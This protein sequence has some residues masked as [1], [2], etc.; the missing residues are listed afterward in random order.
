MTETPYV[1]RKCV[2]EATLACNLR[3]RH[4]GSRAGTARPNELS[5]EE[6]RTLVAD[7]AG[8]GCEKLV[9]SGGEALLRPDCMEII[10]AASGA[11]LRTALITNGLLLDRAACEEAL[12]AGLDAVGVSLDGIGPTH[13]RFRSM[14]GL[15]VRVLEAFDEARRARLPFCAITTVNRLNLGELDELRSLLREAGAYAW[16]LQPAMTMGEICVNPEMGVE[17][18]DIPG[19][20]RAVAELIEAEARGGDRMPIYT[21]DSL[22]YFGPREAVLRR[23]AGGNRFGGCRA[24]V[25][26][27]GIE[28]NGDVKGCL[29]IRPGAGP[30][31]SAWVEGNVRRGGLP[32]IWND[33]AAFAYNRRW[34]PSDLG[35]AC[36]ACPHALRCRGGCRSAM[37][38]S[39]DGTWNPMCERSVLARRSA[40]KG[41]VAGQV[42]AATVLASAL[43]LGASGCHHVSLE[44]P[45]APDSG[46]DTE[47][48][49]DSEPQTVYGMPDTDTDT[50]T[51]T[52]SGSETDVDAGGVPIYAFELPPAD[53]DA[54]PE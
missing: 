16:Q 12:A 40:K 28:S 2:L 39:G 46:T 36:A 53:G 11:G 7:L 1:P 23:Y 50:D 41:R 52:E 4:S 15:F 54:G 5:F 47:S 22:G 19:I 35:G 18:R 32:A 30:E 42:A 49:S 38:T 21:G 51:D 26:V 37:V 14:P 17:P 33:P 13:D 27:V 31:G 9:V 20:S 24:G 10:A 3:C 25:E 29:S 48:E 43:G 6:I 45:G 8:L 44:E 34:K